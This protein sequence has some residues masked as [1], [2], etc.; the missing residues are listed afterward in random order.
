MENN[1]DKKKKGE[2][3]FE[4]SKE[5]Y[6]NRLFEQAE[7]AGFTPEERQQYEESRKEYW[8]T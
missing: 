2:T 8:D 6:I 1:K 5:R 4:E 7:I 3:M